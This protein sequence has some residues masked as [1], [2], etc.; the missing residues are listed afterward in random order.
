LLLLLRRGP[1]WLDRRPVLSKDA[2]LPVARPGRPR[3]ERLLLRPGRLL[4][5]LWLL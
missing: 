3:L 5:L 4:S 1:P 2:L